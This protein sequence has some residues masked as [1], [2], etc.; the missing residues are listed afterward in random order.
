MGAYRPLVICE[1]SYGNSRIIATNDN[2]TSPSFK[3][4][5]DDGVVT[6]EGHAE[7]RALKMM[8][9]SWNPRRVRVEVKRIRKDGTIGLSKPCL[10][11]QSHLWKKDIRARQVFY[12]TDEG[13]LERFRD[14]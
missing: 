2:K 12:T 7:M 6:Y 9:K 13:T 1:I 11:C 14:E 4:T 5:H 8:P 3:K 10:H